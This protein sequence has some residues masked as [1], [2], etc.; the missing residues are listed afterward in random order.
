MINAKVS[1]SDVLMLRNAPTERSFRNRIIG[2][3]ALPGVSIDIRQLC[4]QLAV[5]SVESVKPKDELHE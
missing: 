3:I 2:L 5:G 1:A 4:Q